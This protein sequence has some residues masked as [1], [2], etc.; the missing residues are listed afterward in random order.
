[1]DAEKNKRKKIWRRIVLLTIVIIGAAIFLEAGILKNVNNK[2][3]GKT[4][5]V[6]LEQAISIIEK[7]Q[8]SEE[9]LI[10]SLKE[11]Y[12]VRAK[13]VSY[14]IDAKPEVENDTEEL[15][16][17][18]DLM[19]VDE[20]HLFDETGT[21]YRG[22]VPEYYGYNFDSGEQMAYFKPMLQDKNL[23]MCQDVTPNTS[24][25]KQMMYAITWNEEGNRMVQVGIEP[26]RLFEEVKQNEI[27][28]VV[29]N[30]PMYKGISIYVA[31]YD[32][33]KIYGATDEA[34]I[35]KKLDDVGFKRQELDENDMVRDTVIVD[36]ERYNCI[37][38]KAG[39]YVIGVTFAT[40][41]NDESNFI[42]MAIVAVYLGLAVAC[43][44]FV[45]SRLLKVSKERKTLLHTSNTDELTGCFNR[46]AYERDLAEITLRMEFLYISMDVNGLK[47]VNDSL[48]H[49]A[50]DELLQGAAFCMKKAFGE[51][52]RVYRVG[53]DEFICILFADYTKFEDIIDN[54]NDTVRNWSGQL[55]DSITISCGYVSSKEKS[56]DS[57]KQI[58]EVADIRMYEKKAIYYKSN[59]VDRQGQPAAYIALYKLYSKVLKINL[60]EDSYRVLNLDEND[61]RT[62]NIYRRSSSLSQWF[63][64]FE[65][66]DLIHPDDRQEYM[67]KTDIEYLKQYFEKNKEALSIFYRRKD[68]DGYRRIMIEIIP[69]EGYSE[70]NRR[71]FL[72]VKS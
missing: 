17:I 16:K 43:I 31:D 1:M 22:S 41:S 39:N 23:S 20:I 59:G 71:G 52:G 55:L 26:T 46:R 53:G 37:F 11:D 24:E 15:Q 30:M 64:N 70:T 61:E 12:I 35:G 21:I 38:E 69:V 7:N 29:S 25:G 19:S 28:T 10:Q 34:K 50:G 65:D 56:W 6:F 58:V 2:N 67:E 63:Q 9:E 62:K 18:A 66:Q 47:I 32:T 57:M 44:L 33:G 49:A 4:S 60:T 45:V 14:I 5:R 36:G 54:F 8:K 68:G 13:A 42:A 27:S 51:Y 72:Y 40:S 3:A 48:G